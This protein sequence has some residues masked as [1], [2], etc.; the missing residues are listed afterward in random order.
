MAAPI[1]IV[2]RT[3]LQVIGEGCCNSRSVDYYALSSWRGLSWPFGVCVM[4][5][6]GVLNRVAE[7][8]DVV[9]RARECHHGF[10]N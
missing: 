6:V 4:V 8:T 1:S 5:H 2:S 7:P 9:E 3:G 10:D